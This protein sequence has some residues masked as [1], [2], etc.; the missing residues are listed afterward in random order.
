MKVAIIGA[1]GKT[2]GSLVQQSHDRG[3]QVVAMC[4]NSSI[5]KLDELADCDGITVM[6]AP[7]VSDSSDLWFVPVHSHTLPAIS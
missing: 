4:R 3:Y 2:G 1:S 5:G 7:V 6:S